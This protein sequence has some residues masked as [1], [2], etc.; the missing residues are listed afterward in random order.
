MNNKR[1]NGKRK[2]IESYK[3]KI[4]Q[5]KTKITADYDFNQNRDFPLPKWFEIAVKTELEYGK[6]LLIH[7]LRSF[8]EIK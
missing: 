2:R 6:S 3:I 5:G 8:E 1:A 4:L 7:G